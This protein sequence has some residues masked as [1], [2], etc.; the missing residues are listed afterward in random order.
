MRQSVTIPADLAVKVRRIAKERRLTMSRALVTLAERGVRAELDAEQSLKSA[1]EHFLD[2][3]DPSR[4][5]QA[6]KHLIRAIFGKDAIAEG[7][8]L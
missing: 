1:Y 7:P 5:E 8:L 4:K 2:E 6:G 3:R